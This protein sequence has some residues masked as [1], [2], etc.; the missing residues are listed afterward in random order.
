M[1]VRVLRN[2]LLV[3]LLAGALMCTL[4]LYASG[5][6]EEALRAQIRADLLQDTRSSELSAEEFETM[7]AALAQ[8]VVV[9]GNAE[10]YLEDRAQPDFTADFAQTFTVTPSG[11]PTNGAILGVIALCVALG[12]F[13]YWRS[14][15]PPI[16][17]VMAR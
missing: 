8:E 1:I 12:C 17:G 4:P 15:G 11:Y 14:H 16:R 13:L 9:Q 6:T 10:V 3:P 5:Q 7:V 2:V